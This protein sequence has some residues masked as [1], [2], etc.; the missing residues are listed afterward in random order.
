MMCVTSVTVLCL[1]VVYGADGRA[2]APQAPT[3]VGG[4]EAGSTASCPEMATALGAMMR[5]DVRLRDWANMVRYREDNLNVKLPASGESRVVFMGDSI[6]DGWQ[7]PRYGG[8]FPGKPYLDR[9]ISGQTTPQM[10]LRFRPRRDRSQAGGRGDPG[11]QRRYRR[12]YRSH[13]RMKRSR[14]TSSRSASWLTPTTSGWCSRASRRSAGIM[15]P[16]PMLR[17]RPR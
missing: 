2:Q 1:G 3:M 15:S 11:R 8:F 16:A 5:N 14:A 12:Q 7:Q 10:L 9:G 4:R 13:A 17:R 6:T